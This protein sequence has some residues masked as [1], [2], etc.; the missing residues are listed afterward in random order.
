MVD[1]HLSEEMI[2]ELRR[3]GVEPQ[4]IPVLALPATV[5]IAGFVERLRELPDGAGIAE[6]TR[7]ISSLPRAEPPP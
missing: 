5:T 7:L 6:V 4:E 3:L 1:T 2:R